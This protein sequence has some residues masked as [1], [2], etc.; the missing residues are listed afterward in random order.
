MDE[1]PHFFYP[2]LAER[3]GLNEA[4][5]L[6]QIHSWITTY[7]KDPDRYR[8]KHYHDGAWWT[9]DS[10]PDWHKK[11]PYLSESTIKRTLMNL[12]EKGLVRVGNYNTL[13]ID[14][15]LW[16]TINYG[17]YDRLWANP[18]YTDHQANVT[19]PSDQNDQMEETNLTSP[20]P[21]SSALS[22]PPDL[23]EGGASAPTPPAPPV[24]DDPPVQEKEM[25]PP[26]KKKSLKRNARTRRSTSIAVSFTRTLEKRRGATLCMPLASSPICS[27]C[28]RG[29][30][31]SGT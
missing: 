6:Q 10:Y 30:A 25:I 26:F 3:V 16:Y 24:E 12:R 13:K 20:L 9:W 18:K 14:R 5:V 11:L 17:E 19:P 31:I 4:I 23:E 8:E 22:S 28:G 27:S 21:D 7:T 1:H 2:T 29:C 15:T